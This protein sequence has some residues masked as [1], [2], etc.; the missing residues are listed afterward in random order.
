MAPGSFP[1]SVCGSTTPIFMGSSWWSACDSPAA[2]HGAGG[3][4]FDVGADVAGARDPDA[5]PLPQDVLEGPP[6]PPDGVRAAENQR[7]ER[8]RAHPRP[9]GRIGPHP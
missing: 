7:V 4:R 3:G 6:P 2:R 1:I 5:I 8:E 9:A